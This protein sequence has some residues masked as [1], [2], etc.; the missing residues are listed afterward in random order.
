MRAKKEIQIQVRSGFG[1]GMYKTFYSPVS[2]FKFLRMQFKA[3]HENQNS[4]LQQN[5]RDFLCDN[6]TV[7]AK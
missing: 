3:M 5:F 7:V 4:R 1:I 2:A 6:Y